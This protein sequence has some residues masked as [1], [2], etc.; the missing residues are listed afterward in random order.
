MKTSPENGVQENASVFARQTE[1]SGLRSWLRE[2]RSFL[3]HGPSG[4]GK[5]LL[6]SAIRPEIPKLL[7]SAQN[8]TPQAVYRNLAGT[9]LA[10]GDRAVARLGS[11]GTAFLSDKSALTIK[12]VVRDA[13]RN[14]GYFIVLD[15]LLRPSQALAAVIREL[16]VSCSVPVVAVARSDHMEDAGFVAPLF[17]DRTERFGIRNFDPETAAQFAQR[18]ADAESL[19]AENMAQFLEK[20]VEYSD[21]NPGAML[22]MVR[23]AKAAKYLH[24]GHIKVAPLYI[25]YK[26]TTVAG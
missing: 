18:R 10:E 8:A 15:H 12:G 25:D 9:L 24:Q 26:L 16:R 14:S 2:R 20:V 23:M 5:T 3:L 1:M 6:L 17:P 13:I 4:V 11:G 21:G 19:Q 22:Q 7:Y